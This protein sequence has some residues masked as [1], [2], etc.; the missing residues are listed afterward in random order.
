MPI[1]DHPSFNRPGLQTRLWR[2]MDLPKFLSL[3]TGRQL[4]LVSA[5]VLARDDPHEATLSN[6]QFMHRAWKDHEEVPDYFMKQIIT[7]YSKGTDGTAKSAFRMFAM[8]QEQISH[9]TLAGRRSYFVN[10][11]HAAPHESVA[12]WKIYAS[13][14]LGLAIVSNGARLAE[15]LRNTDVELHLGSIRYFD[16]SKD[17]VNWSNGFNVVM[18]KRSPFSYEEEVR[19]VYWDTSDMFDPLAN[20]KWNDESLRFD[21]IVP[22]PELTKEGM[23]IQC[24]LDALIQEVVVSPSAPQWYTDTVRQVCERFDL[25]ASVRQS[26]LLAPPRT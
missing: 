6:T 2:Y 20:D 10:C 16:E 25:R 14:G 3:L 5:E 19:L 8:E 21:D 4:W 9:M 22:L 13:P 24:D 23:A 7:H 17:Q 26:T 11:W 15:S 1:K 12:M 18:A